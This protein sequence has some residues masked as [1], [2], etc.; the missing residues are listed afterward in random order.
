MIQ[1]GRLADLYDDPFATGVCRE[2]GTQ[3]QHLGPL[4]QLGIPFNSP[5][6]QTRC[7]LE[8]G[9]QW[10]PVSAGDV[11]DDWCAPCLRQAG[12]GS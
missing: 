6:F 10:R 9:T 1:A 7:G 8:G 4:S 5:L 12:L 2:S 3:V 11:Q